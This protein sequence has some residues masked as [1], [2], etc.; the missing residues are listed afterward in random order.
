MESQTQQELRRPGAL[1]SAIDA[2][3]PASAL[4]GDPDARRIA[5]MTAL[6]P[7]LLALIL[8]GNA[9]LELIAERHSFALASLGC[10]VFCC[11][12]IAF[13]RLGGSQSAAANLFAFCAGLPL[14]A[15]ALL[16]GGQSLLTVACVASVPIVTAVLV[17]RR[18]LIG[19]VAFSAA[20]LL[21]G[22]LLAGRT[23]DQQQWGPVDG[24][25]IFAV[26][27][28]LMAAVALFTSIGRAL[29]DEMRL[30]KLERDEARH[31]LSLRLAAVQRVSGVGG[32]EFDI[33]KR[34]LWWS[35]GMYEILGAD[36]SSG[37]LAE[38]NDTEFVHSPDRDGLKD[39][40]LRS[41]F[42]DGPF[43]RE[44]RVRRGDGELRTLRLESRPERDAAGKVAFVVGT[45]E[46][47]T[48][49]NA[50]QR[51]LEAYRER[52]EELVDDRTREL[53]QSRAQLL[54]S[55]RLASIGTLAA[56]IAHQVNNPISSILACAQYALV[57]EGS[58]G[59]RSTWREALRTSAEEAKRC[60]QIVRSLLQFAR[61]EPTEKRVEDLGA[62]VRRCVRL[63]SGFA[64]DVGVELELT[65][66]SDPIPVRM[67]AIEMEQVVVN[68]VR[69]AIESGPASGRVEIVTGC[70]SGRAQA[71]V[72]D[73]GVGVESEAQPRVFDPFF[74]TR[75]EEGGT[76]LGLA[77]AL[78]IVTDHGGTIQLDS[79]HGSGTQVIV[80]LPLAPAS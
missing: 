52:L 53:E 35:D 28:V 51:E 25:S 33:C 24:E 18:A 4:A 32:W 59:E 10:A 65:E 42:V 78:G 47:V 75:L 68:I 56:G 43:S 79:K 30:E 17:S 45:A 69:N 11:V 67:S 76:G 2:F 50:L 34:R 14:A 9:G 70:F 22:Q 6:A 41:G 46:D 48:E 23:P 26:G 19:W 63:L 74:T 57:V 54:E 16:T 38:F 71:C 77:V 61:R 58:Q 80:D 21:V 13:S 20:V 1:L 8:V 44:V 37:P 39:P 31:L 66:S 5:R 15:V 12:P 72:R 27:F 36:P 40:A 60:G 64:L 49:S 29:H 7:A 73:D 62:V 55:E 3:L